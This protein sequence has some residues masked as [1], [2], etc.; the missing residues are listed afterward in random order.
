MIVHTLLEQ[1][2]AS[3]HIGRILSARTALL[4]LPRVWLSRLLPDAI[5]DVVTLDH[6]W[7]YRRLIEL[8]KDLDG[9]LFEAY[10]DYGIATGEGDIYEAATDLRGGGEGRPGH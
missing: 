3:Q 5:R 4:S 7:E 2:C 1:A 8:L 6:E 10:V 9:P